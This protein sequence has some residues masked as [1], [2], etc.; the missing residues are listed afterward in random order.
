ACLA[1]A[2]VCLVPSRFEAF[3]YTCLEAM[4]CGRPVVASKVGGLPEIISDGQDGQLVAPDDPDALS[5]AV[6]GLLTD[7]DLRWRLGSAARATVLQRFAAPVVARAVTAL[8]IDAAAA[9][10]LGP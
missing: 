10:T 6:I 9:A 3:G 2:S 4:S 8:Y 7:P 1:R 5:E